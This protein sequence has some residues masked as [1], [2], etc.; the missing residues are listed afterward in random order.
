LFISLLADPSLS[1]FITFVFVFIAV[2]RIESRTKDVFGLE[3]GEA[4]EFE[5]KVSVSINH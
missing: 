1:P 2:Q 5:D 3:D 4:A